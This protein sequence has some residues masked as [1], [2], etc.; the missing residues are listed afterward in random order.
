MAVISQT[1]TLLP[2]FVYEKEDILAVS[3]EWLRDVPHE[4]ELFDRFIS[5]SQ[6]IRRHFAIPLEMI[7]QLNGAEFRAETFKT[8]GR[9]LLSGVVSKLLEKSSRSAQ[10]IDHLLFTSCSSP[11]IPAIDVGMIDDLHFSG[12]VNRVPIYQHGCAGGIIGLALANRLIREGECAVLSSVELCS[13]IYQAE[14]LSGGNLVGSAIFGDGAAAI[15]LADQ[16]EGLKF[17]SS[18]SHLIPKSAHLMGYDVRDNG[19]HLRL[20][21]SLPQALALNAPPFLRNVLQ[22]IGKSPEDIDWWLFHPGGVKI[23]SALEETFSIRR[24]K[25]R[26]AWEVLERYGNMSSAS[27]LYVLESFMDSQTAQPGDLVCML[28]VGPGLTIETILL[29]QQ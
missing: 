4:R 6:I 19:S 24:A 27:I 21:R 29:E 14:D 9:K 10:D 3:A 17:I 22:T 12:G 26:W 18:Q 8:E 11:T 7:T 20:D 25:S 5:S 13:L 2:E 15:Y 1:A 23:L 28:G 16:G